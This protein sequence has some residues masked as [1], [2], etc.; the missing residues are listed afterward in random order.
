MK[1]TKRKI[2]AGAVCVGCSFFAVGAAS[3]LKEKINGGALPVSINSY[4]TEKPIIVL[5][6]G[7]GG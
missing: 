5:D 7:H 1:K 4:E 6:A 2:I 3:V